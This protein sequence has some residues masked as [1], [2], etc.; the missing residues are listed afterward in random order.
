V[1]KQT[2]Y[3]YG[4]ACLFALILYQTFKHFYKESENTLTEIEKIRLRRM[5]YRE[6]DDIV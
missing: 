1:K 6:E 5:R 4:V 2:L 3:Y